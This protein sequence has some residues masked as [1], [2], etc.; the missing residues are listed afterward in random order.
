M[1]AILF[2]ITTI[3]TGII[4]FY[5]AFKG[6]KRKDQILLNDDRKIKF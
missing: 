1:W 2:S 4:I 3:L 5:F 6:N